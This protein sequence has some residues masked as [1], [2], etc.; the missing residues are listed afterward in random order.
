MQAQI[1]YRALHVEVSFFRPG[2]RISAYWEYCIPI[3]QDPVLNKECLIH[4]LIS[5]LISST[6]SEIKFSPNYYFFIHQDEKY[7]I[8]SG[9]DFPTLYAFHAQLD[10]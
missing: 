7:G 1:I 9:K 10:R 2:L 4:T 3:N 8:D 5:Q 6:R